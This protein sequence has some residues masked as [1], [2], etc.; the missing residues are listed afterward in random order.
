[1]VLGLA[2]AAFAGSSALYGADGESWDPRG[3]LPDFSYAGYRAGEAP[4]P[5]VAVV[6]NVRDQG[7]VGDGVRRPVKRGGF[8]FEVRLPP[9]GHYHPWPMPVRV[10]SRV[11]SRI[12]RIA[13]SAVPDGAGSVQFGLVGPGGSGS[14][15][16]LGAIAERLTARGQAV[17]SMTGRRLERDQA[18]GAVARAKGFLQV[19]SSPLTRSSYHAGED[20]AEMKAAREARL[21][22]QQA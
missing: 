14:S 18:F 7:A 21:A 10:V 9:T 16:V 5:D 1:M 17:L 11:P 22:K 15:E 19:A 13:A 4:I 2:I 8:G 20:F 3:R 6:A 12:A